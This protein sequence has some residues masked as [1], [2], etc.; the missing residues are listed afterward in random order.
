MH[1]AIIVAT[2]PALRP[3]WAK[4]VNQKPENKTQARPQHRNRRSNSILAIESHRIEVDLPSSSLE[5]CTTALE[6]KNEGEVE[7][8]ARLSQDLNRIRKT[9]DIRM[10]DIQKLEGKRIP[11]YSSL[12]DK[13]RFVE[14]MV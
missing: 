10:Q 8:K 12:S 13:E 2:I 9:S 4:R 1:I 14:D 7:C 6:C 3:L 5:T 11:E